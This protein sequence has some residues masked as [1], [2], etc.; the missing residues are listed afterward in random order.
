MR[1]GSE[2]ADHKHPHAAEIRP[3]SHG[4]TACHCP[5]AR[6][7]VKNRRLGWVMLW[8]VLTGQARF[9]PNIR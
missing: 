5:Q 1:L 6:K 2:L 8:T 9:E 3:H 4:A 7:D